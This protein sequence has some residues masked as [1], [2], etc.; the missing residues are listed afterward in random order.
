MRLSACTKT[1]RLL[2]GKPSPKGALV[3]LDRTELPKSS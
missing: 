1:F 2:T 3:K